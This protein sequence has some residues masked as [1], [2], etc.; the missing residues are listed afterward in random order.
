[1]G[2]ITD[3][4]RYINERITI[5]AQKSGR[6]REDITFLAVTKTVP[7]EFINEAI[8]S[9]ITDV[10]ENKVQELLSK[11][12]LLKKSRMHLIGHLQ[13]NKIKY[14]YDKVDLIHSVDSV[15]L[16]KALDDFGKKKGITFK[17]L[18]QVNIGD[19]ETKYGL[20]P[21]NLN[22]FFNQTKDFD[23]IQFEGLMAMAPYDENPENVRKY[24]SE[25]KHFFDNLKY[26]D[27]KNVQM[28]HLSMG[29]SNDFEVAIE[30]GATIVRI[31]SLLFGE[32]NYN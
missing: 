31:G 3:N 29:M 27:F 24:F 28:K 1:M 15:K 6:N 25:M 4:I 17:V 8:D 7:A 13:T 30:E 9:G 26:N 2:N 14:I 5:A 16:A 21:D 20:H 32:R 11:F 22:D 19:E 23:N 18:A 12:D 10:A